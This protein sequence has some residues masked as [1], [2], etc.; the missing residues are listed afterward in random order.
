MFN[1]KYQEKAS[2]LSSM[3]DGSDTDMFTVVL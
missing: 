1:R 3:W 2:Y